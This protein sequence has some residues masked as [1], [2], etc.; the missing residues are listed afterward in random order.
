MKDGFFVE[1]CYE[2]QPKMTKT[3]IIFIYLNSSLICVLS[4]VCKV[5]YTPGAPACKIIFT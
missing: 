1:S 2:I 3:R 4:K 5:C